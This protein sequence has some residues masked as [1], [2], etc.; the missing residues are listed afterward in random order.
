VT[1]KHIYVYKPCQAFSC[2]HLLHCRK[3]HAVH[4]GLIILHTAANETVVLCRLGFVFMDKGLTAVSSAIRILE[5]K[6]IFYK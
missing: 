3:H 6:T 4:H 1:V 2:S 5:K